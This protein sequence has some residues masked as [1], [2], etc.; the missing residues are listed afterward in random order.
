MPGW[1]I[2]DMSAFTGN[3]SVRKHTL[4]ADETSV[5]PLVD[6]SGLLL[7]PD[8]TVTSGALA[9]LATEG[10]G[11]SLTSH[12]ARGTAT[13]IGPSSHD[14]VAARHR[15]QSELSQPAAKRLWR[16]VVKAK[17]R[18]QASNTAADG[19]KKLSE[20]AGGVRSG[21]TTN[22]EGRAA[23]LYWSLIRPHPN[24]RRDK[25]RRDPWN[26]ALNYGYGV[27]RS[28]T[29]AA[30]YAA[31]LWPSLGI[32]HRHRS[33]AGCLVDDLM[34]P[35]RPLV[36]RI[37]FDEIEPDEFLKPENKRLLAGVLE[38]EAPNGEQ[39]RAAINSWAQDVGVYLEDPAL[40][41]PSPPLV[42][43]PKEATDGESADVDPADV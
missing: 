6:I 37:A 31:G 10:I 28:H 15:Q 43:E 2:L 7:G 40:P 9:T 3:I 13:V 14:R 21:D 22:A 23:R 38:R 32:H 18:A 25:D 30:V 36:D 16:T 1:R 17:I 11:I 24:W 4:F 27:I 34:E 29:F 35:F 19:R 41:V 8:V 20:I 33:N 5:A 39:V 12:R 42:L 26:L